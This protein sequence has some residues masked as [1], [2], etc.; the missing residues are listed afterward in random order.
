M[1]EL[2]VKTLYSQNHGFSVPD[3]VSSS[4]FSFAVDVTLYNYSYPVSV[5]KFMFENGFKKPQ[6]D[7]QCPK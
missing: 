6:D 4:W 1:I 2:T 5:K 7:G 3:D